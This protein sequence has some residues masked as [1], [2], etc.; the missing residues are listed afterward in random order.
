MKKM[1]NAL[2]VL[3]TI[4]SFTACQKEDTA[5]DVTQYKDALCYN[6][7]G[8]IVPCTEYNNPEY[9]ASL[10]DAKSQDKK[11]WGGGCYKYV[12]GVQ[13]LGLECWRSPI[14]NCASAFMCTVCA[15]CG[16]PGDCMER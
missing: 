4:I 15:N 1:T 9:L 5:P 12:N 7:Q 3:I 16:N 13:C 2:L 6:E 10:N 14:S 11:Y 8:F